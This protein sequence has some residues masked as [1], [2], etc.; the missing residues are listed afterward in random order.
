MKPNALATVE[1]PIE[2]ICHDSPEGLVPMFRV[3]SGKNDRYVGEN[4]VIKDGHVVHCMTSE[5]IA[6]ADIGTLRFEQYIEY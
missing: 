6:K 1:W 4:V 3:V 5:R 2:M